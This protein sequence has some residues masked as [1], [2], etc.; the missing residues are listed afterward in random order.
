VN[1][2]PTWNSDSADHCPNQSMTQRLNN[3]G[4]VA[5]RLLNSSLTGFIVNTM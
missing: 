4:E 2:N 1:S 5:L 3:A